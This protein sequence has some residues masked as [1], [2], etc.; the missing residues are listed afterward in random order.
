[1]CKLN[2]LSLILLGI[3]ALSSSC[4]DKEENYFNI[5]QSKFE[6]HYTAGQT[7]ALRIDNPKNKDIDSV[8]IFVNDQR[9]GSTKGATEYKMPIDG[10]KLG[11]MNLKTLVYYEGK[12][13]PQ[14]S[15]ARVEVVSN[16][17][18]KLIGYTLVNSYPHDTASF[19]QGLEFYRDTLIETTGQ[20]GNS[21]LLKTDYKTG[22]IYKSLGL[23]QQYFGEG[24]TII[25][26]KIFYLTWQEQTGFIYNADTW[27]LEKTFTYDRKIE[28]WGMTNDGKWIYH[29]DGTEK[30][31]RMDPKTQ[32]LLD[33]INVYTASTKI[34]QV[35]EL[36]YVDGKIYGNVWQKD[37]IA[38]IDVTNGAVTGII[39]LSALR[40]KISH[41]AAEVL[42][43]IA[44]NKKTGTFFVTG[45]Y[46][47]KMFEI[48]L[49]E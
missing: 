29:S 21:R 30:I 14:E 20:R 47:D 7:L 13:D 31:W 22:K 10:K 46:W 42:N 4:S 5:D 32:K 17:Q 8:V 49:T 1:M 41:P 3:A 15:L 18:P 36:E 37:A 25:D 38:V 6:K 40:S 2:P 16:V 35:N 19:T 28:G 45:K 24:V 43:G 33:H 39:D 23:D 48:K 34:K 26:G 11:Y 27:K 44:Y 9:M 12:A